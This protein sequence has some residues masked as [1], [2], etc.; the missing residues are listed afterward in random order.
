[1]RLLFV[2][3]ALGLSACSNPPDPQIAQPKARAA[4]PEQAA[5]QALDKA[6]AVQRELDDAEARRRESEREAE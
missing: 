2:L 1:M 5:R 4:A 3:A 6:N